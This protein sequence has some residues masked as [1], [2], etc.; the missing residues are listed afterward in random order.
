MYRRIWLPASVLLI[1]SGLLLGW[2]LLTAQ[3]PKSPQ[4]TPEGFRGE[5]VFIE[6]TDGGF[7]LLHKPEVRSLAGKTYLVGDTIAVSGVTQD[8]LF[9]PMAQWVAMEKIRRMGESNSPSVIGD[10]QSIAERLK[11]AAGK[12]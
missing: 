6:K 7:V 3:S 2:S 9:A 11:S 8:E 4:M 12:K 5:C 1:L 10:I